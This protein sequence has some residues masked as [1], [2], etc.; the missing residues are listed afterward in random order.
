MQEGSVPPIAHAPNR[1]GANWAAPITLGLITASVSVFNPTLL[2]FVP[3]AFMMI[4]LQPRRPAL[5]MIALLLL[6][7]TFIGKPDGVL[8]WYARGW[9]LIVSAWFVLAVVLMPA[10]SMT[11]RGLAAIAGSVVS[12]AAL[13]AIN[14]SGWYTLDFAIGHQLRTAAADIVAFW[15]QRLQDK[16]WADDMSGVIYSFTEF[17]QATYPAM[18]A[19]ASFT[20][21]GLAWWVWRRVSIRDAR[22]LG[23]LRDFKFN[24]ELVWLVVIGAALLVAP[25]HGAADR[26]GANLL[27]FMAAL[28]A[29]RG[30]AVIVA[31]FGAP[32]LFGAL[33]GA[34]LLL[35]LYPVVMAT[36]LMV[37]LTDTWLDL[38]ARRRKSSG[39]D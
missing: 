15:G 38:R 21:L 8:W 39:Q 37:G 24:D 30:L 27:T 16:P 7:T 34:F 17:Q 33:F 23:A 28:Y 25:L 20:G 29:V 22:P 12:V 36:T 3:L 19:I 10:A 6:A 5:V 32:T 4:A 31:L 13:F 18:I 11:A 2:V 14:K 26:A 1:P 35:M 9:A